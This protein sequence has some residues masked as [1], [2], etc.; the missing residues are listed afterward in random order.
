[1]QAIME[2]PETKIQLPENT[3]TR[4]FDIFDKTAFSVM[5]KYLVTEGV[6]GHPGAYNEFTNEI[7]KLKL[8]L[9]YQL[10][11]DDKKQKMIVT[12]SDKPIVPTNEKITKKE[13]R[14]LQST[15]TL[16][17]KLIHREGQGARGYTAT[18]Q[19]SDNYIY[20][21]DN[22]Q[23]GFSRLILSY[24]LIEF[25]IN[26]K[27]GGNFDKCRR[28]AV[29]YWYAY[30]FNREKGRNDRAKEYK[31]FCDDYP[32]SSEYLH[33]GDQNN[34]LKFLNYSI[35]ILIKRIIKFQG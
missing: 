4:L 5:K 14:K 24:D 7:E 15:A 26:N 16:Y 23:G 1:M 10:I 30:G 11:V 12:R 13:Q 8:D 19:L 2:K 3:T 25:V 20:S 32:E 29:I 28:S 9:D 21:L 27:L 33:W 22:P 6:F 35:M 18:Y 31:Q 34:I 17:R